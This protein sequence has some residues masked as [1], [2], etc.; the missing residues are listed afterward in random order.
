MKQLDAQAIEHL[1]SVIPDHP[2]LSLI[3]FSEKADDISYA[4]KKMCKE[5]RK[6]THTQKSEWGLQQLATVNRLVETI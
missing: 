2:A 1:L 6:V 3:Q 5:K 4:I